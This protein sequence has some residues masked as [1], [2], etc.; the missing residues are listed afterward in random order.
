MIL[1]KDSKPPPLC[2]QCTA[3]AFLGLTN[4]C[5]NRNAPECSLEY[6][7]VISSVTRWCHSLDELDRLDELDELGELDDSLTSIAL[8]LFN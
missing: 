8:V 4:T 6:S 1:T 3:A 7:L 5:G 2:H